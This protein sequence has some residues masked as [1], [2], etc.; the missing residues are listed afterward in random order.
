VLDPSN[1]TAVPAGQSPKNAADSNQYAS[2]GVSLTR[3]ADGRVLI[4]NGTA[5]AI[6]DPVTLVAK[7]IVG[8]L[9]ARAG[10]TATLL[11]DG[12]VLIVGGDTLPADGGVPM[13]PATEF[14]DPR[15]LP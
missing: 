3:L 2:S 8:P 4:I 10:H 6:W 11:D 7:P 12:R 15:A 1:S 13:P 5:A 14:F 9:A